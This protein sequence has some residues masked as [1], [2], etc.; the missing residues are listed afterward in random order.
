[1]QRVFD[2]LVTLLSEAFVRILSRH[3]RVRCSNY[4]CIKSSESAPL[5]EGDRS[6]GGWTK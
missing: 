6:D 4:V 5:N 3:I 1:M 2:L